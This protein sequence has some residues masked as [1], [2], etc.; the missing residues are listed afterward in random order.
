M[1]E[2]RACLRRQCASTGVDTRAATARYPR[3]TGVFVDTLTRDYS[4]RPQRTRMPVT[5]ADPAC[6]ETAWRQKENG[7]LTVIHSNSHLYLP[8]QAGDV[9]RLC[10]DWLNDSVVQYYMRMLNERE[11]QRAHALAGPA[12]YCCL[13][14]ILGYEGAWADNAVTMDRSV[15]Y[16][17]PT[18]PLMSG[19]NMFHCEKVV[20]P[21]CSFDPDS[22]H[23]FLVVLDQRR[24]C[25][26][27]YDSGRIF[28]VR[29]RH[30]MLHVR[31]WW[32]QMWRLLFE[33]YP[34][35]IMDWNL[36]QTDQTYE[37]QQPD[38]KACGV[39]ACK[40]ADYLCDNVAVPVLVDAERMRTK[41][42]AEICAGINSETGDKSGRLF[43]YQYET[44]SEA[45][46]EDTDDDDAH[47]K[48][49][50]EMASADRKYTHNNVAK[51]RKEDKDMWQN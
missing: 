26:T 23:W 41:L 27:L 50:R 12:R 29:R 17:H 47:Y 40:F 24:K 46:T 6:T 21:V 37:A 49:V 34:S 10:H 42:T 48:K 8:L 20:V 1:E 25:V 51:M 16:C 11:V 43:Q 28:P 32:H 13:H 39:F 45:R 30:I 14:P 3:Y 7:N 5:V 4:W 2:V 33:S 15:K 31:R 18:M 9:W 36:E 35:D 38:T 22:A 19:I 44:S